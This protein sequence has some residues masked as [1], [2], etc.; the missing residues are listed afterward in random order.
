MSLSKVSEVPCPMKRTV[1]LDS[2]AAVLAL[3]WKQEKSKG[4]IDGKPQ[5]SRPLVV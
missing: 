3:P 1:V 4:D 5:K 2:L